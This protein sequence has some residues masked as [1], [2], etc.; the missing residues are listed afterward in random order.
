MTLQKKTK[1]SSSNPLA[2]QIRCVRNLKVK[3]AY[4]E[5]RTAAFFVRV[6]LNGSTSYVRKILGHQAASFAVS[7]VKQSKSANMTLTHH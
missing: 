4:I 5:C 3:N 2:S 6:L 7:S 1:V